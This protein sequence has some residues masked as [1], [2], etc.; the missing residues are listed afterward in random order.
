MVDR[1]GVPKNGDAGPTGPK[2]NLLKLMPPVN[3]REYYNSKIPGVGYHKLKT[4][5]QSPSMEPTN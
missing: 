2:C 4:P 1:I 3:T 5:S